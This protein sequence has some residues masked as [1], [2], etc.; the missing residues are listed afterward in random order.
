[1]IQFY[2]L[3]EV[4]AYDE[5]PLSSDQMKGYGI[6]KNHVES[7]FAQVTKTLNC[8]CCVQVFIVETGT[9]WSNLCQFYEIPEWACAVSLSGHIFIKC[10][11]LWSKF[12]IGT[13]E[14]TVLH[15]SV[16][17]LLGV[18]YDTSLPIWLNE[19]LAIYLSDQSKYYSP[20]PIKDID[21]NK[22]TYSDKDL[23]DLSISK[24]LKMLESQSIES[25]L[26]PFQKGGENY[27]TL[28]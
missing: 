25:I 23:Y 17:C 16:H 9:L 28:N 10:K 7:G 21:F 27:E 11:S 1:M 12:N 3:M 6:R 2:K 20:V 8:Q 14:E 19:G 5:N 22:L 18:L 15:E 24:L 4:G 13:I 26:K